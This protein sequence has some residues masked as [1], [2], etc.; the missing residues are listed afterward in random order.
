MSLDRTAQT[1]EFLRDHLMLSQ[2][3][4][5]LALK[6]TPPE[7]DVLPIILWNYGLVNLSQLGLI[8]DYFDSYF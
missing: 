6:K 7:R 1:I 3:S 4:I 5:D 8:Y 2:E